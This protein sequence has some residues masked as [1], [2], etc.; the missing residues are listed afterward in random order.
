MNA[1]PSENRRAPAGAQLLSN[2]ETERSR[3]IVRRWK[4]QP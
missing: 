1:G 3:F 2:K 4:L